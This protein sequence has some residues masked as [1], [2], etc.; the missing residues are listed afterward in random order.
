M[1]RPRTSFFRSLSVQLLG[2]TI[3]FAAL[4]ALIIYIP[5][6]AQFWKN[7]LDQRL[8]AAQIAALSLEETPG[9]EV[10][11]MLEAELLSSAE[12]QAVIDTL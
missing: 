12:I 7:Y 11:P 1:E 8:V 4:V 2:L 10:S 5:S 6:V 3:F 9:Q